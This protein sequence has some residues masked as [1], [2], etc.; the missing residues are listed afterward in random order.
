[1][2]LNLREW[3]ISTSEIYYRYLK[4]NYRNIFDNTICNLIELI[5]YV[6]K[7]YEKIIRK[8]ILASEIYKT[9][10]FK[11]IGDRDKLIEIFT[12]L[13]DNSIFTAIKT[14]KL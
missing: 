6:I 4:L 14:M 12:N 7:T 8:N 5:D 13:I 1:M 11:I 10:N 9:D 3:K 2:R